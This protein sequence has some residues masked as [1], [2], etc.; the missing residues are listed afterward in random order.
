[1]AFLYVPPEEVLAV[2]A[3]VGFQGTPDLRD[4]WHDATDGLTTVRF[5]R[6]LVARERE[7]LYDV[8]RLEE[9]LEALEAE[10]AWASREHIRWR[11]AVEI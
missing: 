3:S 8:D 7:L 2:L 6:D 11:L 10:L 1:M 4:P 9:E 5:L